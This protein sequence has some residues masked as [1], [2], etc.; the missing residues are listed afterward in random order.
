M[1]DLAQ[2]F[3]PLLPFADGLG[4]VAAL[5]SMVA[6]LGPLGSL[7]LGLAIG[8]WGPNDAVLGFVLLAIALVVFSALTFRAV[9]EA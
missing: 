7:G 4:R 1:R 3:A 5:Y 9:R 6:G 8:R 2:C